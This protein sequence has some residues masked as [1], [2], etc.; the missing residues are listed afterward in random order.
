MSVVIFGDNFTF[1][2]GNA[3]TNRVYTYAKGFIENGEEASVICFGNEYLPESEGIVE[4]IRYFHPYNQKNRSNSL[5]VRSWLKLVKYV[6]TI[7]LIKKLNSDNKIDAIITYTKISSSHLFSFLLARIVGTK[8]IIENS[9][10]PLRYYQKGFLNRMIGKFKL[11]LELKTF[12]GILLIT[13]LLVDFYKPIVKNDSKIL[14]VPST[15]DPTR[16]AIT[17][18]KNAE[19]E[20]IGYFGSIDFERDN[21]DLLINAYAMINEKHENIHLVLGG[22]VYKKEEKMIFD[23]IKSLN[24]ES[25]VHIIKYLSREEIIKY[26]VNAHV[27]VLVRHD[28]PFTEASFP[29][30]Y[31][32]YLSTGNPVISVRVS[33][34]PR[35]I[36][37]SDNG[38]LVKNGDV[39]ELSEK[40][41]YVLNN[42]Q[43]ASEV[44]RRGKELTNSVFNYGFQAKR[45]IQFIKS[46]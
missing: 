25:K 45:I 10:H 8:L 34:I 15:V 21:L 46:V 43:V 38:F 33:E 44:G 14:L 39:K 13:Q 27:L 40:L 42:Y 3:S 11:K 9:E 35:Y 19:Y 20:Y 32:E 24:I 2:E 17:K 28:D 4:G 18:S 23:L 36:I 41:E 1:P 30:K 29:C 12:D 22:M 7:K 31:T 16:F 26:V 37:D 5:I 6:N